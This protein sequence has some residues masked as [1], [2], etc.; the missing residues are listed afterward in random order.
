M[1]VSDVLVSLEVIGPW[2][3]VVA[4]WLAVIGGCV[5]VGAI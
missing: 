5:L 3:T 4:K 2:Y 1:G